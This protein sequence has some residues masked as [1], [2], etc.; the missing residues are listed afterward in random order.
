VTYNVLE[1][2]MLIPHFSRSA[3]AS[4]VQAWG[5]VAAIG[6]A[7]WLGRQSEL[8]RKHG[9]L[10][11]YI[12]FK[13][14][15]RDCLHGASQKA[16]NHDLQGVLY[17]QARIHDAVQLGQTVPLHLLPDLDALT[18]TKFRSLIAEASGFLDHT[19][20]TSRNVI[21]YQH[22]EGEFARMLAQL[23][24]IDEVHRPASAETVAS[25]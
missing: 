16:Q 7:I 20:A 23:E 3:C 2:C 9:A 18:A 12:L 4:W 19:I 25:K 22:I 1:T 8:G 17:A 15:V 5:S 11:H 14:A 6:V 24:K 10:N 21:S 13:T